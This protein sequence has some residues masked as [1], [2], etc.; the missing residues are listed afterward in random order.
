[1]VDLRGGLRALPGRG[2]S[3]ACSLLFVYGSLRAG[4]A[5][6][7]HHLLRGRADY[8]D[9]GMCQ[10]RLYDLGDYPGL[11]PSADPGDRVVGEIYALRAAR[12]A[13]ARL[14]RYEGRDYRRELGAVD[15]RRFGRL[16]AWLYYYAGALAAAP[17]I[18][19][20]DYLAH[21]RRRAAGA[22]AVS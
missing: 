5:G 15:S 19:S 22:G 3:A 17:R 21:L 18:A 8:L 1:M 12:P 2:P 10:G 7:A 20:G 11:M 9:G 6:P 14:D 13:L 4:I 16:Q